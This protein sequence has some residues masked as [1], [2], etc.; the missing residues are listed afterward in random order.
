M[1]ELLRT[2]IYFGKL[3]VNSPTL[4]SRA[5][6][7]TSLH[8]MYT[9]VY[10]TFIKFILFCRGQALDV[11]IVA[12]Q[13]LTSMQYLILLPDRPFIHQVTLRCLLHSTPFPSNIPHTIFSN[14]LPL[15]Y[16]KY[17]IS[18]N[19]FLNSIRLCILN[20]CVTDK[21]FIFIRRLYPHSRIDNYSFLVCSSS[22]HNSCRGK[23]CIAT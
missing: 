7:Q 9:F 8:K 18:S 12:N 20:I 16:S 19:T 17:H 23:L 22:C 21:H 3:E 2:G 6:A 1:Q 5:A 11:P 4:P 10:R 13:R 14:F 15:L